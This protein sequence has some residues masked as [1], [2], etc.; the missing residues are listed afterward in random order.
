MEKKSTKEKAVD[1]PIV[2]LT[3][4]DGQEIKVVK[5]KGMLYILQPWISLQEFM[6]RSEGQ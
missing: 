5:S 6:T 2:I 3:T 1:V 4:A